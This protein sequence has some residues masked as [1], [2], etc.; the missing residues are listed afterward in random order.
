MHILQ[1]G[2]LGYRC[3]RE[4]LTLWSTALACTARNNSSNACE[5]LR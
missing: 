4:R 2:T 1:V 5:L 3:Q